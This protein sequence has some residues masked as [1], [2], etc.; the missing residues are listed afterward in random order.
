M[1]KARC[2]PILK[3]ISLILVVAFCCTEMSYAASLE[4]PAIK[5]SPLETI[6][7][8]PASFQAPFDFVSLKEIH[9]GS[10]KTFIIH[11]QDAH[12]NLSGQQNL[13]NALDE[14]M[15][16]YKVSLVLVEG[17]SRDD[18]L[19]PIKDIAPPEVWKKVAK[20]FLIE[21]KISGEEYLNL[22]SDHPMKI[23]GIE[24]KELYMKSLHAYA[25]LTYNRAETLEYLKNIQ[26]ALDKLKRKL[27]PQE[28]IQYEKSA[29]GDGS[30]NFEVKFGE[31][32]KLAGFAA[33]E[34]FRDF[35]NLQKLATLQEKEKKIDFGLANLEQA[36][37]IEA[38]TQKGKG[39]EFEDY[40]NKMSQ[41]SGQKVPQLTY[42]RNTLNIA[43]QNNI[44]VS[45]FQ[46]F[47]AYGKYLEVFSGLDLEKVLE[48]IE[49][50]EDFVFVSKLSTEDAKLVRAID[51][52][53]TLLM[54]AHNIKMSTKEFGLFKTNG[55][56]FATQGYL[57]FINRKLAE[58]GF[59]RDLV[60]YQ[61]VLEKGKKSLEFFYDSV[62]QRDFAFIKNT[63]KI[64]KKE[65]QKV[66]VLISGGYHTPHLRE[67]FK[68]KGY[69]YAVLEPIVTSE[70]NQ[71]KYERVLLACIKK[72]K[73][74]VESL[75]G[76]S[77][78][79]KSLSALEK[80]LVL[81]K[82]KTDGIRKQPSPEDLTPNGFKSLLIKAADMAGTPKEKVAEATLRLATNGRESIQAT[83]PEL[84]M[85]GARMA[86]SNAS[87]ETAAKVVDRLFGMAAQ[88][89]VIFP[90]EDSRVLSLNIN[91]Q[92]YY[93]T[94]QSQSRGT[95][96]RVEMDKDPLVLSFMGDVEIHVSPV[97]VDPDI[98]KESSTDVRKDLIFTL[99][100]LGNLI[101][102][103]EE[104]NTGTLASTVLIMGRFMVFVRPPLASD[105]RKSLG[106]S[107][108]IDISNNLKPSSDAIRIKPDDIAVGARMAK[109][110][111]S[112]I[113][114]KEAKI[115]RMVNTF[116]SAKTKYGR[117]RQLYVQYKEMGVPGMGEMLAHTADVRETGQLMEIFG[118]LFAADA[119]VQKILP[120]SRPV[121]M[122]VF[123]NGL[124]L[125]TL[126]VA[127]DGVLYVV[128]AKE[129]WPEYE[130]VPSII[131]NTVNSQVR[132]QKKAFDRLR[133][134]GIDV[135]HV[136]AV[137]GKG[138]ADENEGKLVPYA[139]IEGIPVYSV[140]I[141]QDVTDDAARES[142][143]SLREE[144]VEKLAGE[145]TGIWR[146]LQS[147]FPEILTDEEVARQEALE[148]EERD[149]R[150]L[151]TKIRRE[152]A[153]PERAQFEPPP[154][155]PAKSQ[156]GMGERIRSEV[157]GWLDSFKPLIEEGRATEDGMRGLLRAYFILGIRRWHQAKKENGRLQGI[158][159]LSLPRRE[160][161]RAFARESGAERA[162]VWLNNE[163]FRADSEGT[164]RARLGAAPATKPA[165]SS[166]PVAAGARMA[167]A[168]E[169]ESRPLTEGELIAKLRSG[170]AS[171][172][173]QATLSL[174][175]EKPL[176][177]EALDALLELLENDD[178]EIR[179][180]AAQAFFHQRTL[181]ASK[182]L[183]VFRRGLTDK[184]N[185]SY[186]RAVLAEMLG[187]MGPAA[188]EAAPDLL[189]LLAEEEGTPIIV[190]RSA[191]GALPKIAPD[192]PEVAEALLKIWESKNPE[193]RQSAVQSID[194]MNAKQKV[195]LLK[196]ALESSDSFV[197]RNAAWA[198][199]QVGA[200]AG[201]AIPALTQA[202]RDT[203]PDVAREVD[204][205]IKKIRATSTG[206]RLAEMQDEAVQKE[207]MEKVSARLEKLGLK[208][209]LRIYFY[210]K[211]S[212][213][214]KIRARFVSFNTPEHVGGLTNGIGEIHIPIDPDITQQEKQSLIDSIVHEAIHGNTTLM[215]SP[216]LYE[217]AAYAFMYEVSTE[218]IEAKVQR[219]LHHILTIDNHYER[220]PYVQIMNAA[221]AMMTGYWGDLFSK[222]GP[223]PLAK[224]YLVVR[225]LVEYQ[226]KQ[227][228][229]YA[230]ANKEILSKIIE[231]GSL[232]AFFRYA[233]QQLPEVTNWADR[234]VNQI[235]SLPETGYQKLFDA[236]LSAPFTSSVTGTR[237]ATVKQPKRARSPGVSERVRWFFDRVSSSIFRRRSELKSM[238]PD[239]KKYLKE[240]GGGVDVD[241]D[242]EVYEKAL[243]KLLILE[244]KLEEAK[245]VKDYRT[246]LEAY[247]ADP[248]LAG[249]KRESPDAFP[250]FI[251]DGKGRVYQYEAGG[252]ETDIYRDLIDITD[253]SNPAMD[254]NQALRI[255]HPS[256]NVAKA[257]IESYVFLMSYLRERG[258]PMPKM[259]AGRITIFGTGE[260]PIVS[261][262]WVKGTPVEQVWVPDIK[263][264]ATQEVSRIV[265]DIN[266]LSSA[267]GLG[268]IADVGRNV[269]NP[270]AHYANFIYSSPE[271]AKKS[272]I[273]VDPVAMETIK[274]KADLIKQVRRK[275]LG[276]RLADVDER[277]VQL[278]GY[279]RYDHLDRERIE[280][281]QKEVR[282]FEEKYG[283]NFTTMVGDLYQNSE[284]AGLLQKHNYAD[285]ILQ[286][287]AVSPGIVDKLNS[288]DTDR[289]RLVNEA[290]QKIARYL[291]DPREFQEWARKV[292]EAK[293]PGESRI[294]IADL[295]LDLWLI[296]HRRVDVTE[297]NFKKGVV[298]IMAQA[299]FTDVSGTEEWF[300]ASFKIGSQ[301]FRRILDFSAEKAPHHFFIFNMAHELGHHSLLPSTMSP[302]AER[303]EIMAD[304]FA[305]SFLESMGFSKEDVKKQLVTAKEQGIVDPNQGR[306]LLYS[307]LFKFSEDNPPL[308][309]LQGRYPFSLLLAD[310]RSVLLKYPNLPGNLLI[311][312]IR[313]RRAEE[314]DRSVSAGSS[315]SRLAVIKEYG[316]IVTMIQQDPELRDVYRVLK[317]AEER[318]RQ[319]HWVD[320]HEQGVAVKAYQIAEK[321]KSAWNLTDR[322]LAE[323]ALAAAFH[324]MGKADPDIKK[325]IISPKRFADVKDAKE[326]DRLIH[327]IQL[328]VEKGIEII[329]NLNAAL[330]RAGLS[331][332]SSVI[333]AIWE[334]HENLDG[335]GY[336]K[337]LKAP[338]ISPFGKILR[339]AD[340]Y[341]AIT[342]V[343]PY[344]KK[345][346]AK[347]AYGMIKKEVGVSYDSEV[348]EALRHVLD[349][350]GV[351]LGSRLAIKTGL[352]PFAGSQKLGPATFAFQSAV[353]M[354][355]P[356]LRAKSLSAA[357][358]ADIMEKV[359][360]I[361][362]EKVI[363]RDLDD[364][365]AKSR[366]DKLMFFVMDGDLLIGE[367]TNNAGVYLNIAQI[368]GKWRLSVIKLFPQSWWKDKQKL[369]KVLELAQVLGKLGVGP[370]FYGVIL[371]KDKQIVGYAMQPIRGRPMDSFR[372]IKHSDGLEIMTRLAQ[373]DLGPSLDFMETPQGV[374][375]VDA[376][377][378]L[379]LYDDFLD[380]PNK[381]YLDFVSPAGARM[382]LLRPASPEAT[383]GFEGQADR[384]QVSF[385]LESVV[386]AVDLEKE[387]SPQRKSEL[388]ILFIVGNPNLINGFTKEQL[389]FVSRKI[390]DSMRPLF[391]KLFP[392]AKAIENAVVSLESRKYL[393]RQGEKKPRIF[394]PTS[395]MIKFA[396]ETAGKISSGARLGAAQPP[397]RFF[398]VFK[399]S[400]GRLSMDRFIKTAEAAEKVTPET[401][402]LV[403]K[404][405][406]ALDEN[407]ISDF[408]P[409]EVDAKEGEAVVAKIG[410]VT[411]KLSKDPKSGEVTGGAVEFHDPDNPDAEPVSLPLSP[412]VIMEAQT[413]PI[414][415]EEVPVVAEKIKTSDLIEAFSRISQTVRLKQKYDKSPEAQIATKQDIIVAVPVAPGRNLK[416]FGVL[417]KFYEAFKP[418]LTNRFYL[419]FTNESVFKDGKLNILA[420][421]GSYQSASLEGVKENAKIIVLN[422]PKDEAS[423]K[424]VSGKAGFAP[425][426]WAEADK[427]KLQTA[428][429]GIALMLMDMMAG[430]DTEALAKVAGKDEFR[431]LLDNAVADKTAFKVSEDRNPYYKA[432]DYIDSVKEGLT[433][434]DIQYYRAIQFE[435]L[436]PFTIEELLELS[437]MVKAIGT[438]A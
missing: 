402:V 174:A 74:V 363:L 104:K 306:R 217:P 136:V 205:A 421:T 12:S 276:G 310:A 260:V 223:A 42:F 249:V 283:K 16:K 23:M 125:D 221:L 171:A 158:S 255:Y 427:D 97:I 251:Y 110:E 173:K 96:S 29:A 90:P 312:E 56:D 416:E 40:L 293:T 284:S 57:A 53:I 366:V 358:S 67:L 247:F 212:L 178:R 387:F 264:Y 95:V 139:E 82:K 404:V 13:A 430:L 388:R 413:R 73:K 383:Q 410:L 70:T 170:D 134:L 69:S 45:K 60:A 406:L 157:E 436:K 324:D 325:L 253:P 144:S 300:D 326:R 331:V 323:L 209:S 113:A 390:P 167:Q 356:V 130:A 33:L 58:Q 285:F 334:H 431:R 273:V 242:L 48:E 131:I 121:A 385:D 265:Q 193:L 1:Y 433:A 277:L 374:V 233:E 422:S 336:P 350:E 201:E 377:N 304:L 59:Y 32:R 214:W 137:V 257:D 303:A 215:I 9:K 199:G 54:T 111:E 355:M 373:I 27:Y 8:D 213:S 35:P 292:V 302:D 226:L 346:T 339:V 426:P 295:Y 117:F 98:I 330:K 319:I 135:R 259:S 200:P 142:I 220:N 124:E 258:V 156:R 20:S 155:K 266:R 267:L 428:N 286:L 411:A 296:M 372:A 307:W 275:L 84:M 30:Q 230:V 218:S 420:D 107:R 102:K 39:K 395:E 94:A 386:A 289:E 344:Q 210:P 269:L 235:L 262:E 400:G 309:P 188:K 297:D 49:K 52:Y 159:P 409:L 116:W 338:D 114:T 165:D 7:Q 100:H 21:G 211:N 141:D 43:E 378:L 392:D 206:A 340:S 183:P 6:L 99:V 282:A 184:T 435:F 216:Y 18:T 337:G 66:A 359:H 369:R 245:T 352:A 208:K 429:Y 85:T 341:D 317:K 169:E 152:R 50:L 63:E 244:A 92:G 202:S 405:L 248:D 46:N 126:L 22:I 318:A 120:G 343:R 176:S 238:S 194:F 437:Q 118:E 399:I 246:L 432:A 88:L 239:T 149:R 320:W 195:S 254:N 417:M 109:S 342:H 270:N 328:H 127:K 15:S 228:K 333:R 14:I 305:Y 175:T 370:E 438:A 17:G 11:I 147:S 256:Q 41:M 129:V 75:Q 301:W 37:L 361:D 19:T 65:D 232:R 140:V 187:R 55:P 106:V 10:E 77:K 44:E 401:L 177:G 68:E 91:Q 290:Y 192:S 197:R 172:Q 219:D 168:P 196:R 360:D 234:S 2:R 332:S 133:K 349:K 207:V 384:D 299:A 423:L 24:D 182:A 272:V 274:E 314:F 397:A 222:K 204:S 153:R 186:A 327:T 103:T 225:A 367:G 351:A 203:D 243:K 231:L 354:K 119:L 78:S 224:S 298:V 80:D 280:E 34:Q 316:P 394:K 281:L 229:N 160:L 376:D 189:L 271:P 434:Q 146:I 407:K 412:A 268:N 71:E 122:T 150:E 198:L 365:V 185:I 321:L 105:L 345:R 191:A 335:S 163:V 414:S 408:T 381:S 87:Q 31:L 179:M 123:L 237:L 61:N 227:G 86:V 28:L 250:F 132:N 47:L 101:G 382:A 79:G 51:R 311:W 418:Y 288:L 236:F 162:L 240:K 164:A 425:V 380:H 364:I 166:L 138:I 357:F 313:D 391:K 322:E 403:T 261:T 148:Q 396:N 371:N 278:L 38:I 419:V 151:E 362:P 291:T 315:G 348:V 329:E 25:D 353:D 143:P 93:V 76:Q 115:R 3:L 279:F 375:A 36:S 181:D 128:E 62:A 398:D 154:S 145:E 81:Q 64:L 415:K 252:G 389:W 294:L 424:A 241:R 5:P 72:E 112:R 308:D 263:S 393:D 379:I 26:T 4:P 108:M 161:Q 83:E 347:E 287:P 89:P 368:G 190:W 180:F